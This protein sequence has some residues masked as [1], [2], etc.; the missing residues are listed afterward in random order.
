[1]YCLYYINNI[2]SALYVCEYICVIVLHLAHI[3]SG[4]CPSLFLFLYIELHLYFIYIHTH[5]DT[6]YMSCHIH[7]YT[8]YI[9][10]LYTHTHTYNYIRTIYNGCWVPYP[11]AVPTGRY[12]DQRPVVQ[13]IQMR[14]P[15]SGPTPCPWSSA[16]TA[17]GLDGLCSLSDVGRSRLCLHPR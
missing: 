10:T 3:T 14:F 15:K 7:I 9:I 11:H 17:A 5:N 2:T 6:H 8:I 13:T 12:C 16:Q 4:L 1:M